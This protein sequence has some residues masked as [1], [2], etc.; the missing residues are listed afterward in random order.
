MKK[1]IALSIFIL[2]PFFVHA[3][4][5]TTKGLKWAES[6]GIEYHIKAGF[7]VGGTSPLP[8]PEEIRAIKSY[9]PSLDFTI[10]ADITKWLTGKWG[11][12]TGI[13]LEN[14][15]MTTKARVKNYNM[16]MIDKEAGSIAGRWTGNIETKVKNTYIS[17]PVLAAYRLNADWK[18]LGGAFFS[19]MTEGDFSGTAYNGYLR[20]K[21]PTGTK[22]NISEAYYDFSDDLSKFQWGAQLGAEWKAFKHFS[23]IANLTWGFEDIF[24]KDFETITF[25]LYPIYLNVGFGYKF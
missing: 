16:V 22:I 21:V 2:I 9:R 3:Q 10:E 4:E 24:K 18:L 6:R 23:V 12:E 25:S 8:L 20:D 11:I 15:G 19:Y 5:E 17:V 1:Y 14:K 13:R 7:N